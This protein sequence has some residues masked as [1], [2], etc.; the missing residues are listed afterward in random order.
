MQGV[1]SARVTL[2]PEVDGE[3]NPSVHDVSNRKNGST[4]IWPH[5]ALREYRP[6][7]SSGHI[8]MLL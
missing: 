4:N 7:Q 3:L 1:R 6:A 2:V 8:G 5:R